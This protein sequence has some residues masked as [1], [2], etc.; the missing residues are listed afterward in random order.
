MNE[1]KFRET[2]KK[3]TYRYRKNNAEKIRKQDRE[4]KRKARLKRQLI[5]SCEKSMDETFQTMRPALFKW[6][7]FFAHWDKNF[8]INELV[9]V[10]FANGSLR[11]IKNP[12]LLSKKVKWTM[13][14][15]MCK[16][17]REHDPDKLVQMYVDM[18]GRLPANV[19]EKSDNDND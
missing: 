5:A 10:A 15:Y 6:A 16:I 1:K 4:R 11:R 7:Q 12:K 19:E 9:N 18:Y 8:E 14:N 13:Q 2:R 17:R 3:I